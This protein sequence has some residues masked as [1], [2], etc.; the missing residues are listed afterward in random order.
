MNE[1]R[2]TFHLDKLVRDKLPAMMEE[3]GQEPE[4]R[5]L[6]NE[7]LVRAL[8]AKVAEELAELNPEE[9]DF[10]KELSQVLQAV[11]DLIEL[12]DTNGEV[13]QLRQQDLAKRGGFLDGQY[14][15]ALHLRPDDPWVNYYRKDPVKNKEG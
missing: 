4:V 10:K 8:I 7:E 9:P 1:Q 11:L 12:T 13:E 15:S 14:I 6:S 2:I 5:Q 3:L